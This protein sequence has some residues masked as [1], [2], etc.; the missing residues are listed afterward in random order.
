MIL[1]SEMQGNFTKNFNRL[2][3]QEKEI[4]RILSQSE[5]GVTKS[6]LNLILLLSEIDLIQNLQ[7]LQ[8][9]FLVKKK[10][11]EKQFFNY[12]LCLRNM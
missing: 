9:R 8:K 11:A 4:I 2:S 3:L 12:L 10:E 6:E 5:K 1:F 7:S